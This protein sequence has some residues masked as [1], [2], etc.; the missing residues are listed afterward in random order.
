LSQTLIFCHFQ[1]W[2]P[3]PTS[4]KTPGYFLIP[5]L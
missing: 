3:L 1:Y 4:G 2:V 5:L